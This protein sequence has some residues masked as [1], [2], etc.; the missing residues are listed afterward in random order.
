MFLDFLAL[1]ISGFV[2]WFVVPRG[3]GKLGASF[4]F[5]R[6]TWLSIHDVTSVIVVVLILIH[7]ILN[8]AW[9]KSVTKSTLTKN[10]RNK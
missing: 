9:I 4:I 7:L 8:W 1:A 2:L 10:N 6:E 3:S 5:L